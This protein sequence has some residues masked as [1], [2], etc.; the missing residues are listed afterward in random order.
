MREHEIELF[1]LVEHL[2]LGDPA[3]SDRSYRAT[4]DAPIALLLE[5]T[6]PS[7]VAEI[8]RLGAIEARLEE[9]PRLQ[10]R[11]ETRRQ[12][13]QLDPS[14]LSRQSGPHA[15]VHTLRFVTMMRPNESSSAAGS[16]SAMAASRNVVADHR[17]NAELCSGAR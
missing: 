14:C 16:Y 8:G 5:Q 10:R 6:R 13:M 12:A 7:D 9:T 11:G 17:S 15:H 3:P 1:D 4:A 2:E